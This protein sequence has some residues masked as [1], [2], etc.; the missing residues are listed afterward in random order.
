M[1]VRR[2]SG[3]L[4]FVE[5]GL[6]EYMTAWQQQR[7][8]AE[9]LASGA[10]PD[11]VLLLE[12]PSVYTAGRRTRPE[13][14]PM[15]GTPWWTW[16]AADGSPGTGRGSWS[17]TIVALSEPVDVVAYVRVL[18]Q[19]L[20][21]RAAPSASGLGGWR[22]SGFGCPG[23]RFSRS[24]RWPRSGCGSPGASPARFR[25]ELRLRLDGFGAIVPCGIVD[26]GV[27]TLSA[28]AGRPVT[29]EEMKPIVR[30]TLADALDGRLPV[31][32]CEIEKSVVG[33]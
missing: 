15:D 25:A 21:G 30:E 17:V 31:T 12:H 18:E 29:V 28:E 8:L 22:P 13:D 10:G 4:R 27:T 7:D 19:A 11:T 32:E 24:G 14:R 33:S 2:T 16:T 9:A 6:V 23:T 26:A 3:P 20:I 1:G 5:P